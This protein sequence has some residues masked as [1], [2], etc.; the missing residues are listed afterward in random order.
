MLSYGPYDA[1]VEDM[2]VVSVIIEAKNKW[3][4]WAP[5]ASN[6]ILQGILANQTFEEAVLAL[7]FNTLPQL[8]HVNAIQ[9]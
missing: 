1:K 2:V 7:G 9:P 4:W 5:Y 8:R 3:E 6:I